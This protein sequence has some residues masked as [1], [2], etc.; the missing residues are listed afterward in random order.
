MRRAWKPLT[1]RERLR[2][3]GHRLT[4]QRARVLGAVEQLGHATPGEVFAHVQGDGINLSTVYRTLE[5]LNELGLIRHAHLTDRAPTYHALGDREHF[6]LVCRGCRSVLS[7]SGEEIAGFAVS[8]EGQPQIL[9]GSRP[10]DR[11]PGCVRTVCET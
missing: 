7:V 10:S 9:V 11:V 1:W 2:R 3:S 5:L 8:V 4:P 6:H